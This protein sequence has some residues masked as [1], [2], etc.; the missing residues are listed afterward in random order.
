MSQEPKSPAPF[1]EVG[2]E[3]LK[4]PQCRRCQRGLEMLKQCNVCDACFDVKEGAIQLFCPSCSQTFPCPPWGVGANCPACEKGE[5]E[6]DATLTYPPAPKENVCP[7]CVSSQKHALQHNPNADVSFV[8]CLPHRLLQ[9]VTQY[10]AKF[11][12]EA[13]EIE[14]YPLPNF[15]LHEAICL[16]E[17][18]EEDGTTQ[19][20]HSAAVIVLE[21]KYPTHYESGAFFGQ[22]PLTLLNKADDVEWDTYAHAPEN[23]TLWGTVIAYLPVSL[24]GD[25]AHGWTFYVLL[26]TNYVGGEYVDRR[27]GVAFSTIERDTYASGPVWGYLPDPHVALALASCVG[28]QHLRVVHNT[29]TMNGINHAHENFPAN[30]IAALPEY[31]QREQC[32]K[33][34]VS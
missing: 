22:N 17:E 8:R 26:S 12:R 3:A 2:G 31:H 6:Q 19:Q 5:L 11:G 16:L 7:Y 30:E 28:W 10:L 15:L 14:K 20:E 32:E 18:N 4:K 25:K 9:P 1:S 33:C 13:T 27:L 29:C 23:A 34:N 24:K 21:K